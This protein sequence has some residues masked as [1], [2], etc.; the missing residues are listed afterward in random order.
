[1]DMVVREVGLIALGKSLVRKQYHP[2]NKEPLSEPVQWD[3]LVAAIESFAHTVFA[4]EV[5]TFIM[6]DRKFLILTGR[7]LADAK[8]E[9][10]YI[11]A[12][13]DRSAPEKSVRDALNRVH[14][15]FLLE[16]P[17]IRSTTSQEEYYKF[18]NTI[19]DILGDLVLRP[20]DRL[21]RLL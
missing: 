9:L 10:I 13:C 19:D 8:E 3:S 18:A 21:E 16:Y 11:Y 5:E 12:I 20:Q 17:K 1:M 15:A 14:S 4:D 7:I 2:S 6:K